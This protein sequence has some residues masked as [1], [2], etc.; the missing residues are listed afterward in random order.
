MWRLNNTDEI[1]NII[2]EKRIVTY[3]QPI[4]SVAKSSVIGVEALSRG[5]DAEGN[6]VYPPDILFK[7]AEEKEM[8]VELD[9]LCI[10]KAFEA[11]SKLYSEN[12][13]LLLFLNVDAAA[14]EM[15]ASSYYLS[16]TADY[17]DIPCTNVVIEINEAR[18]CDAVKLSN[19]TAE[20]RKKGFLIALDDVGTGFSNLDRMILVKPDIVK[21][22]R[23]IVTGMHKHY[24]M[25]VVF[26]SI[27]SFSKRTGVLV[28]AEG[29]ETEKDA[30][31][32]LGLNSDLMQGYYYSKPKSIEDYDCESCNMH[33]SNIAGA[34]EKLMLE[35]KSEYKVNSKKVEKLRG[36]MLKKLESANEDIVDELLEEMVGNNEDI[37]SAYILDNTGIQVSRTITIGSLKMHACT[38]FTLTQK[39]DNLSMREFVFS[40]I[41]SDLETYTTEAHISLTTGNLCKTVFSRFE[42]FNGKRLVLCIDFAEVPKKFD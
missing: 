36:A 34:F 17:M 20:Y 3:F 35:K 24:T 21:V 38:L 42:G 8:L 33:I 6:V 25:K 7:L 29:V 41:C 14:I 23:A 13:E 10:C 5:V 12:S 31:C 30:L 40:F 4:I 2:S 9:R 22:D 27:V 19:F 28:I 32:L 37:E 18:A 39:G 11:F 16:D 15:D 1:I 26:K